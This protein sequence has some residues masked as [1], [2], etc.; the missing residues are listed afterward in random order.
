MHH[1][2]S[3][4]YY[5]ASTTSPKLDLICAPRVPL[6]P[7]V[8]LDY[9][10]DY[11]SCFRKFSHQGQSLTQLQATMCLPLLCSGLVLGSMPLHLLMAMI[12]H[13]PLSLDLCWQWQKQQ[14]QE[15]S[16]ILCCLATSSMSPIT[17]ES[18]GNSECF[19]WTGCDLCG[20]PCLQQKTEGRMFPWW[21][22]GGKERDNRLGAV[23]LKAETVLCRFI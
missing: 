20:C 2:R 17:Y 22:W 10:S 7:V 6:L 15:L 11:S 5:T 21:V 23:E 4:E 1:Q 16:A 14:E 18:S 9:L 3:A 19:S 13:F 8:I 12:T